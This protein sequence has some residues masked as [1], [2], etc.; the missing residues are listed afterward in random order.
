MSQKKIIG[1]PKLPEGKGK[2]TVFP[3]RMS[4]DEHKTLMDAAKAENSALSPWARNILLS[5]AKRV[6]ES[7]A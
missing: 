6:K 5:H 2:K 7:E 1:R 4:E 3:L